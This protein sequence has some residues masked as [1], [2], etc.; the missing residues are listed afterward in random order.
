[1]E[2]NDEIIKKQIDDTLALLKNTL[3][4]DVLGVYLYGSMLLGG[5]QKFSDI[6]FLAVSKRETT[7]EEKEKLEEAL[8]KISGIYAVS[9]DRK[10]IELTIVVQSDLNPWHYPPTF[11]FLYGD[12]LRKDF[13]VGNVEPWPTKILPNLTLVITQLLLSHKVLF[14]PNPDQLLPSVPY[15]DFLQATTAEIDSLLNDL[16]W[17]TRNVLLTLA[18]IW[19]TVETDTI[20]SKADSASWTIAKLPEEFKPVLIRARTVLLGEK[21]EDWKDLKEIVRPCANFIV[22][23]IKEKT[24]MIIAS[25][26]RDKTI[27][28]AQ[29]Y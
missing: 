11:D 29:I 20:R 2:S 10:P 21:E 27:K 4:E 1:M 18:R 16:D 12:W 23:Q 25:N 26:N 7:K 15:E 24:K 3:G 13:E 14:G 9:K 19:S 28:I 17:D 6:D 22:R 5:L 8:L